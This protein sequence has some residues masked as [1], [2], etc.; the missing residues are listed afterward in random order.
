M[1]PKYHGTR[2]PIDGKQLFWNV[3]PD[4]L[5]IRAGDSPALIDTAAMSAASATRY[6]RS[7]MFAIPAENDAYVGVMDWI[8]NSAAQLYSEIVKEVPDEPGKYIIWLRWIEVRG[9]IPNKPKV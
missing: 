3:H 5:P 9:F 4:G 6:F 8:A 2:D 7:K 1:T